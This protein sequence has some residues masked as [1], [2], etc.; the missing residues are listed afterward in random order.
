MGG[1]GI[2][3]WNIYG[4]FILCCRCAENGLQLCTYVYIIQTCMYFDSGC[5]MYVRR[6]TSRKKTRDLDVAYSFAPTCIYTHIYIYMCSSI[7]TPH[8]SSSS[9]PPW[10]QNKSKSNLNTSYK[11]GLVRVH[12]T[13]AGNSEGEH[14]QRNR[15]PRGAPGA[16]PVDR[17]V[18]S[19]ARG[20]GSRRALFFFSFLPD[21]RASSVGIDIIG[22]W[23]G[24]FARLP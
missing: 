5:C 20:F 19:T 14:L 3:L 7:P 8:P 9:S 2:L 10:N 1:G 23:W 13:S 11:S 18:G 6:R 15:V 12:E 17:G 22:G 21:R 16:E 24:K 4:I